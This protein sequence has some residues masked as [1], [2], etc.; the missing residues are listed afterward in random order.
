MFPPRK[1]IIRPSSIME[2]FLVL[3][4]FYLTVSF[5]GYTNFLQHTFTFLVM[6]EFP[7]SVVPLILVPYFDS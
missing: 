2:A 6:G 4:G 1:S 3:S 5:I 7:L